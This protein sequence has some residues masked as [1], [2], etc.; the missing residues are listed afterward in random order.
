VLCLFDSIQYL[1]CIADQL[2]GFGNN[3]DREL[4]KQL[5]AMKV[6]DEDDDEEN[7]M[8]MPAFITRR[9]IGLKKLQDQSEEIDAEYKKERLALEAKFRG[10]RQPLYDLRQQIVSGAVEPTLTAEDE[11]EIPASESTPEGAPEVKGIP[12][13]WGQCLTNSSV[14]SDAITDDDIPALNYLTDIQCSYNDSMS[15][16]TLEFFFSEN[17][18]FTDA[19]R[20]AWC[21]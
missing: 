20:V 13:F 10:V 9:V 11:A 5:A 14:I 16:F 18:F 19:V 3:M 17:P 8:T 4:H 6:G 1:D 21:L 12:G 15:S 2:K 7:F